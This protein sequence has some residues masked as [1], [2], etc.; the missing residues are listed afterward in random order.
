[1]SASG[2]ASGKITINTQ[3]N[4]AYEFGTCG[5]GHPIPTAEASVVR[6]CRIAILSVLDIRAPLSPPPSPPPILDA[7]EADTSTSYTLSSCC[8]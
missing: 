7:V 4:V 8:I 1:M 3:Y 6:A 2:S 5:G